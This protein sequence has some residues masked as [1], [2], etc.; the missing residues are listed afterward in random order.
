MKVILVCYFSPDN[1]R[2]AC[3]TKIKCNIQKSKHELDKN[4]SFEIA[5]GLLS[6]FSDVEQAIIP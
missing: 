3:I 1:H 2:H 5:P 4:D 6:Q